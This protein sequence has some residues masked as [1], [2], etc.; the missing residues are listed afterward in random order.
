MHDTVIERLYVKVAESFIRQLLVERRAIS[1]RLPSVDEIAGRVGC[2]RET[3][4]QAVQYLIKNGVIRSKH[5]RGLFFESRDAAM[6]LLRAVADKSY[7]SA[8]SDYRLL[9]VTPEVV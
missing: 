7:K 5:G 1:G 6:G 3:A 4:R 8:L 9:G 2:S